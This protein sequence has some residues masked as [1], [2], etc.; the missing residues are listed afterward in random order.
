MI[1]L[2]GCCS[3]GV[4]DSTP[5]NLTI[6]AYNCTSAAKAGSSTFVVKDGDGDTVAS[7]T[8]N[9]ATGILT[10][11]LPAGTYTIEGEYLYG[12][13][14]VSTISVEHVHTCPSGSSISVYFGKTYDQA[15]WETTGTLTTPQGTVSMSG[16]VTSTSAT[17]VGCAIQAWTVTTVDGLGNS[18]I[19]SGSIAAF[20]TVTAQNCN[21]SVTVF[22]HACKV[23]GLSGYARLDTV[24]DSKCSS[25]GYFSSDHSCTSGSPA[26][27][28][29]DSASTC[30]TAA[31]TNPVSVSMTSNKG[32][33]WTFAC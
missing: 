29:A 8:A 9:F 6:T 13:C 22:L 32:S 18:Y 17:Y 7:G 24:T 27:V 28:A 1:G 4:S 30:L 12:A 10:V 33:T 2:L 31:N 15:D 26:S 16:S 21:L 3:C 23:S 20:Y 25:D 14:G 11:S 5:C 19:T